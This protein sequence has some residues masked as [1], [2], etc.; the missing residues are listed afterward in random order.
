MRRPIFN[1]M[2][3]QLCGILIINLLLQVY[4][5]DV[6]GGAK[7][8]H[9]KELLPLDEADIIGMALV[10]LIQISTAG[11]GIGAGAILV[12]MFIWVMGFPQKLA[13]PL[14]NV[15]VFGGALAG[16]GLQLLRRHPRSDRPL[17]DFDLALAMEPLTT[18]GAILGSLA[19]KVSPDLLVC[20]LFVLVVGAVSVRTWLRGSAML[21]EQE[22]EATDIQQSKRE[23][24][25]SLLENEEPAEG[26]FEAGEPEANEPEANI[27]SNP[28]AS[29][30]HGSVPDTAPP[31]QNPQGAEVQKAAVGERTLTLTLTLILTRR[32]RWGREGQL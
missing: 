20:W 28:V 10:A 14:A 32:Q 12:P 22:K 7:V 5:G 21:Q 30:E 13:I 9:R 25:S 6:S 23:E 26:G 31:P 24:A 17:I 18:A 8:K 2:L 11:G 27:E 3:N 19:Q 16:A 1:E 15:T 4:G 29:T